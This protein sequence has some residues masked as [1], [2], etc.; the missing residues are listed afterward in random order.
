MWPWIARLGPGQGGFCSYDIL[1]NLAGCQIHG[2]G[3]L[4]PEW[5]GIE[6]GN[7]VKLAYTNRSRRRRSVST[8][9]G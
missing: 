9:A 3:R 2:A 5:Q 8:G 6:V 1:E 4:I 7:Q